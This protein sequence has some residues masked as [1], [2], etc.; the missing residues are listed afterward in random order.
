MTWW[1]LEQI[2]HFIPSLVQLALAKLCCK[3]FKQE[4]TDVVLPKEQS[5][6]KQP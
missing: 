3:A 1:N 2:G 6:A 4:D 5:R